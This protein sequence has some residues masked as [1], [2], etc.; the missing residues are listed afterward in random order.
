[1]RK[2]IK[3]IAIGC[4]FL[5]SVYILQLAMQKRQATDN[6]IRLHVVANS[7][8]ES[9]Q[10]LK[11]IIKDEIVA[12]LQ[13]EMEKMENVKAAGAYLKE[14]LEQVRAIAEEK[15]ARSGY[16]YP[17]TVSFEQ[18]SFDR[19][20][21]E[22]FSLPA[23]VYQS[24][25]VKIGSGQGKNW[26]CVAFPTLCV[27]ATGD[28]FVSAAVNDGIAEDMARCLADPDSYRI[29]FFLLEQLGRL[30]IFLRGK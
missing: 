3:F 6:L 11:L 19:R 29:R 16:S 2:L 30:E 12:F 4:F 14:N 8:S 18:E 17:V 21:Y 24:L 20:N 26:W 22:T 13:P 1:M 7:D 9:D 25:R 27:P 15:I 5:L 28:G 23:G 10:Q